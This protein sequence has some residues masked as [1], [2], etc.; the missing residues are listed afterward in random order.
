PPTPPSRRLPRFD[1]VRSDHPHRVHDHS[2]FSGGAESGRDFPASALPGAALRQRLSRRQPI[3][4]PLPDIHFV[5]LHC[6]RIRLPNLPRCFRS[7]GSNHDFVHLRT[8]STGVPLRLR[9]RVADPWV[10]L[11]CEAGMRIAYILPHGWRF[12]GW[13]ISDIAERYHFS[14]QLATAMARLG[15]AVTLLLLHESA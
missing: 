11:H 2:N 14:K 10:A 5:E 4:D 12:A 1:S 6:N 7:H 3:L 9:P 13:S 8:D 15:H